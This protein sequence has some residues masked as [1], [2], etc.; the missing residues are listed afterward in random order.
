[1]NTEKNLIV[2]SEDIIDVIEI[3]RK[4]LEMLIALTPTGEIRNALCDQNIETLA[5]IERLNQKKDPEYITNKAK[6]FVEERFVFN[7]KDQSVV[8]LTR[9]HLQKA[10]DT[11]VWN[12]NERNV[13]EDLP[14]N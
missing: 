9:E 4:K 11:F 2:V 10:L 14:V 6:E 12:L 13:K 1:M 5:L 3:L 7:E 8:P